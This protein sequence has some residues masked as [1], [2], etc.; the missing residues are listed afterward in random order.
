MIMTKKYVITTLLTSLALFTG[1]SSESYTTS[2]VDTYVLPHTVIPLDKPAYSITGS[3]IDS[4]IIGVNYVCKILDSNGKLVATGQKGVTNSLGEFTCKSNDTVEFLINDGTSL[5][6][7]GQAPVKRIITPYSLFSSLSKVPQDFAGTNLA[8]FLLSVDTD[9]NPNNGLEPWGQLVSKFNGTLD[10]TATD[11]NTSTDA[12][13][14]NRTL[15][16]ESEAR[17]HLAAQE[18]NANILPGGV[19]FA[20]LETQLITG[21]FMSDV[22]GVNYT[23][24]SKAGVNRATGI[25][26]NNGQFT[27]Y[28]N[29]NVEFNIDG[30]VLGATQANKIITPYSL[31]QSLDNNVSQAAAG[32]HLSQF[33]LTVDSDGD[34]ETGITPHLL[35]VKKFNNNIDFTAADFNTTAPATLGTALVSETV[36]QKYLDNMI[37]NLNL[38]A[39]DAIIGSGSFVTTKIVLKTGQTIKYWSGDDGDIQHGTPKAY[40]D[41]FD[42][43]ITESGMGV[44][45]QNGT[46]AAVNYPSAAEYCD[47]LVLANYEDWRLPGVD[48]LIQLIDRNSTAQPAVDPLFTKVTVLDYWTSTPGYSLDPKNV[49]NGW[50]VS[51]NE[52]SSNANFDRNATIAN[53]LCIR[54]Y[55]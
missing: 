31:F 52:G 12:K 21:A 51:M 23:C 40:K 18:N 19:L 41:N 16:T 53:A 26:D 35:L 27:C 22:I 14:G 46:K 17:A 55:K 24:K 4:N 39:S 30:L 10:F 6:S 20:P 44:M 3:F 5:L 45:W 36:A 48:E 49:T 7:L 38:Q 28:N 2:E 32:L 34:S 1:C 50:T 37:T 43:T 9:Q 8:M 13:L 15:W 42:G 47:Q 25:T 29:E 54:N 33:L 11:F